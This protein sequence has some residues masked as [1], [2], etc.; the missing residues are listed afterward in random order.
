[1]SSRAFRTLRSP[2]PFPPRPTEEKKKTIFYF[3]VSQDGDKT[4]QAGPVAGKFIFDANT[5]F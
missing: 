5:P 1:M 3:T 2:P 4:G